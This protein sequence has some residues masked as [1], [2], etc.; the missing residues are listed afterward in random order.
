MRIQLSY[1]PSGSLVIEIADACGECNHAHPTE[2]EQWN[3]II[4]E[5]SG[6]LAK[7]SPICRSFPG[8]LPWA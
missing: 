8:I 1:S 6:W 2:I 3:H 7:N 5:T 4:A